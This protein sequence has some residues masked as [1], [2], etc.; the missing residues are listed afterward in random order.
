[1]RGRPWRL[2]LGG[3]AH[4]LHVALVEVLEARERH[5]VAAVDAPGDLDDG[6]HRER[7]V[8]E[9]L[10]AHGA[11]VRGHAVQDEGGRGDDPVAALLLHAGQ[12]AEH[13]VRDVLAQAGLAEA[14]ALELED[15]LA[16]RASGRRPRSGGCGSAR[17]AAS[18]ILPRL[19]SRR[20]TSI[21]SASGVTMRQEAR[22]STAVP[23]STA[24]LPPAF[25]AMLPPMQEASA[26]VGSTAKTRPGVLG[27]LHHAARDG[28]RAHA[29][30]VDRA[31]RRPAAPSSRPA[32]SQSS[33]SVFTTAERASSGMAPP[34]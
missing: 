15:L 8:A 28:A 4:R 18:W 21:Q 34:V 33:F 24:F 19:W 14:P 25:M 3:V 13:L 5:A 1:M 32:P 20:S 30:H 16:L 11:R 29:D 10:Q 22:L 2:R 7:H 31:A 9:E 6:G 23:H 26:E 12:P 27:G 17:A